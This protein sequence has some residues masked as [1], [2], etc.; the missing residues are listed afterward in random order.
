MRRADAPVPVNKAWPQV[1]PSSVQHTTCTTQNNARLIRRA[2]NE[3]PSTTNLED[4][5]KLGG[6]GVRV[7]RFHIREQRLLGSAS[8]ALDRQELHAGSAA[9]GGVT[10]TARCECAFVRARV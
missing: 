2:H 5:Q 1:V 4:A 7:L 10:V 9:M 8:G 6:R 3:G